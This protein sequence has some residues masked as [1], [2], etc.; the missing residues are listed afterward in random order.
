MAA[1]GSLV[2]DL[3]AQTA[4]FNANISKAASNLGSNASKMQKS[5]Q[6]IERSVKSTSDNLNAL[7]DAFLVT[8][9][10]RI[11]K[12]A[13]DYASSLGEVSQ[14]IGITVKDLQVYRYA[15]SQVG[16]SNEEMEK[17]LGKLTQTLGKAQ[18]G[19]K[20]SADVFSA[21]GVSIRKSGGDLKSTSDI[22]PELAN[23]ISRIQ[24]PAQRAAVEVA[25]FGRAGQKLDTL[26][27]G[28]SDAINEMAK[29]AT[30][31]GMVM[32]DDL[33]NSA[34]AAADRIGEL[35]M[36]LEANISRVVAENAGS[37]LSLANSIAYLTGKA[38]E[39]I[40][41]NPRLVAALAGAAAGSRF[42]LPGAG[43]GA[44][45]GYLAG[46]AAAN[47]SAD[48]NM[49]VRFRTGQLNNATKELN[50]RLAA[51]KSSSLVSFRSSTSTTGGTVQS[52]LAELRKQRSLLAQARKGKPAA[53][54][55]AASTLSDL[56][57]PQI[58][59]SGGGG[60]SKAKT[61]AEK[62][63]ETYKKQNEELA[64][65][66]VEWQRQLQIDALRNQGM[67]L[68]ADLLQDQYD[69]EEKF[70]QRVKETN[71]EYAKRIAV[72]L[73]AKQAISQQSAIADIGKNPI[74][75]TGDAKARID[76][77][78]STISTKA[79]E[80]TSYVQ[81]MAKTINGDLDYGLK[82]L[83]RGFG[84]LQDVA[85]N[86]LANIGD[87][88]LDNLFAGIN[89]PDGS[90]GIGGAIA[91]AIGGLFGKKVPGKAVGGP[92]AGGSMYMVGERGP[93]LFVP[94]A[95]GRIVPNH[96]LSGVQRAINAGNDNSRGPS[97][98]YQTIQFTGAVD[99]AT[100][101]E[102]YRV[103]DAARV[104]AIKGVR[105]GNRRAG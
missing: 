78:W 51:Q 48:G 58:M 15:G 8:E 91:G 28:G 23:A 102:V 84:S 3:I 55:A 11:G 85:I 72:A 13:L 5:L 101:S 88:I 69:I 96:A 33:A 47:S 98:V 38:V 1:V 61:D 2:I 65:A 37:I 99:L 25:L 94:N 74:E 64:K 22:L 34:D 67:N 97:A 21:L 40:G 44:V 82:G 90:G 63:L 71:E 76:N 100:R 79:K 24:D 92:V 12:A 75:I 66:T 29:R 83:I 18:L 31:L 81:E 32:S 6:S 104:A 27:A 49:D 53:A 89:G 30:D 19:S 77:A 59:A 41:Q 57:L 93:E 56:D 42:G 70:P 14:Q 46:D 86:V 60:G 36:Q 35:K 62:L 87:A 4:S 68:S 7:R 10:I 95:G 39:F 103:A 105:E 80:T 20:S 26:L 17:G 54:P 52:A 16:V 73:N 45:G 50:A 9:G 43:V